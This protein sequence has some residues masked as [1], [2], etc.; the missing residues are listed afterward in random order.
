MAE[1]RYDI[2]G[3]VTGLNSA[4]NA[5]KGILENL[6][7]TANNLKINLLGA[8]TEKDLNSIGG[9][10]TIITGKI[11][12]YTNAA[13]QGS[14]AFKDQQGQ[15]A[16]DALSVKLSVLNGNAQLFGQSIQN[17]QGQI[18]A[19]Q[20]TIDSLL[21][22]GF[23]PLDAR[24]QSFKNTIDSLTK[25]VEAQKQAA[26]GIT[27]PYAQF[28]TTGSLIIDAENKVRN[29]EKALRSATNTRDIALYNTRLVEANTQLNTLRNTGLRAADAQTVLANAT[30]RA[31]S[32]YN[33]VGIELGRIIQDAP[34]AANNLGAIGNNVTRLVEVIPAYVASTSAAIVANGGVATSANVAKAALA[35]LF[36][37]FGAVI[38][39]VSAVVSGFVIYQQIQQANARKAAEHTNELEKQKKA[40]QDYIGTLD[41]VSQV[42]AK[43]AASYDTEVTKLDILFQSLKNNSD[44]RY[45]NV[46]ALDELQKSWPK[47]FGNLEKGVGFVD[48]LSAAYSKLRFNLV[49]TGIAAAAQSLSA[50]ATKKLVE[51]T[52]ALAGA[53]KAVIDAQSEYNKKLEEYN[54]LRFAPNRGG[55]AGGGAGTSELNDASSA[56]AN[57][58]NA[59]LA[60][61]DAAAT[62][63]IDAFKARQEI[64]KFNKASID[65]Q[66]KLTN[67]VDSGLVL[68]LEKEIRLL[69]DQQPFIKTKADLEANVLAIKQKQAEL[70][71]LLGKNTNAQLAQTQKVVSLQDQLTTILEKAKKSSGQSGLSG[72]QLDL[73]KILDEYGGLNKEINSFIE[74]VKL[75]QDAFQKTNGKKGISQ[76][77]GNN[78][79]EQALGA[80]GSIV[81]PFNKEI[82]DAQIKE[83]LRVS[84]EIQR[85]ND[86]YGIKA[87]E[88]KEKELASLKAFYDRELA[89][90]KGNAEIIASLNS[91]KPIAEAAINKKY[92]DRGAQDFLDFFSKINKKQQKDADKAENQLANTIS[93]SLRNFGQDFI[94]TLTTA[95]TY[96]QGTFASIF[97]D[98]TAKLSSSLN[99][100]FNDIVLNGLASAL[101]KAISAGTGGLFKDGKITGLG[102]GIAGAG[103]LGGVISA[104]TPKTST[105]GQGAGGA[106]SGAAAGAAIGS[107]VPVIGTVAGAVVGGVVGL[108]G[109]IFGSASARKK[110]EELQK[111][112][113]DEAKKQTELLRQQQAAYTSSIIGRFTQQGVVSGVQVGATGQ[114]VATISGKDIQFVLDRNKNG[115]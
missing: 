42:S 110:Q 28:R 76:A 91:G 41:K 29:L 111:Q 6:Q 40:L 53:D 7:Q 99:K 86:Q 61:K 36:S 73:R 84:N 89:L 4:A 96:T 60:A 5:A 27:D 33:G 44:A 90:A 71:A 65:A 14:Q 87:A 46:K 10:L 55:A 38:L 31:G 103:I 39:A 100:V 66:S 18:R 105:I 30:R 58:K 67:P 113:L 8:T 22:N 92:A 26:K 106:L 25:S 1:L 20:S 102:A 108:I 16:I 101:S 13:I 23:D 15:A 107:V 82:G 12:D 104:A 47:E 17:S 9:A 88:S 109:G 24:V 93:R 2:T 11:K 59:L 34:Y 94:D 80:K 57:A 62:F 74:N 32:S 72:Y 21:K 48:Q 77:D 56:A 50:E 69:Q 3:S 85:I 52:V 45:N 35:G 115:R 75:L 114:L 81:D 37:G 70:D 112:Q 98:L 54:K 79:I 83:A 78:L 95:E 63:R 43:A 49:Q 51:N 64:D 19:Y 68:N 97:A